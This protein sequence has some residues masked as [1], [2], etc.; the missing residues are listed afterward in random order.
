MD[1]KLF[2]QAV[3]EHRNN[4][5][6]IGVLVLIFIIIGIL[7]VEFYV[8][9]ILDCRFFKIG[10]HRFSPTVLMSIPV[11]FV[12]LYFPIEISKCNADIKEMAYVEY[13]GQVKYSESSVKLLDD[14]LSFFVGKGHEKIPKGINYGKVVYSKRSKVIVCYKSIGQ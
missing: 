13:I 1:Y 14:G 6:L 12:L 9:R 8:R 5:I 11:V 10:K 2:N 4:L 7:V 3:I